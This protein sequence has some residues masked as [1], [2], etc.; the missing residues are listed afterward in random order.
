M[1]Q[2]HMMH[3]LFLTMQSFSM[4]TYM[5][6]HVQY[7]HV[8]NSCACACIVVVVLLC[9][10][11]ELLHLLSRPSL[12]MS[13]D[14]MIS[15]CFFTAVH[16]CTVR[17]LVHCTHVNVGIPGT[18]RIQLHVHVQSNTVGLLLFQ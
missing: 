12:V 1:Q 10:F 8:K 9:S 18:S 16:T 2:E 17:V 14:L 11:V 13:D 3:C 6:I 5:Y 7:A 4:Y 15:P